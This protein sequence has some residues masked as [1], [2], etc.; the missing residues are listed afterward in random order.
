MAEDPQ[1]AADRKKWLASYQKKYY[2]ELYRSDPQHKH[3]MLAFGKF[4]R[5]FTVIRGIMKSEI[6][7]LIGCTAMELVA[8]LE[9][10]FE[11]DMNWSNYGS[12]WTI[13][14]VIPTGSF[15][16]ANK[17]EV[18]KCWHYKNLRPMC[19]LENIRKGGIRKK[20][21]KYALDLP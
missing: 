3:K 13:D 4:H 5:M 12:R 11:A 7:P 15:D 21:S 18:E 16:L 6:Q 10:L 1:Y 9:S 2:K 19:R 20:K 8:H 17:D 14:H